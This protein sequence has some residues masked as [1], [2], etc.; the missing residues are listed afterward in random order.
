MMKSEKNSVVINFSICFIIINAK[1]IFLSEAG[2]LAGC[3]DG[4]HF[5]LC[6]GVILWVHLWLISFVDFQC[7]THEHD[8]YTDEL[9]C[10][11]GSCH[12][13]CTAFSPRYCNEYE[14]LFYLFLSSVVEYK[15]RNVWC[16]RLIRGWWN[17]SC[18]LNT[19]DYCLINF[20]NL[21]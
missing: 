16:C 19:Y 15:N 6:T 20:L 14:K 17:S 18:F 11:S 9:C 21:F 5:A 1:K 13:A 12:N 2:C 7:Q 10:W 3:E 4:A 8:F